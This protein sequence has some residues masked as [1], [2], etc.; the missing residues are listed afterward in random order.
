MVTGA[1]ALRSSQ[2]AGPVHIGSVQCTGNEKTL[3]NC[4]HITNPSCSH[5]Y[6]ASVQCSG[7]PASSSMQ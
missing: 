5:R 1:L 6:D 7:I 4:T 2:G 3:L